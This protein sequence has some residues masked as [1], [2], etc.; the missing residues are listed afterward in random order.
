M[1]D[2]YHSPLLEALGENENIGA[3]F[4]RLGFEVL[5]VSGWEADEKEGEEHGM[6]N[7]LTRVLAVDPLDGWD[8]DPPEEGFIRLDRW[9]DNDGEPVAPA[10]ALSMMPSPP[11]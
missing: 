8:P 3:F 6:S 2:Q 5:T 4:K 7:T 11:F 9:I 10:H 1:A